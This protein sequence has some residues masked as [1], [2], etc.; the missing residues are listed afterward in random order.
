M[1]DH[2]FNEDVQLGILNKEVTELATNWCSHLEVHPAGGIAMLEQLTGLPIG[3][4]TVACKHATRGGSAAMD[5][6]AV[7][8]EFHD[9]NCVGCPHRQPVSFPNLSQ[10]V[11]ERD[12]VRAQRQAMLEREQEEAANAFKLRQE[13]RA[14]ARRSADSLRATTVDLIEEL[15]KSY[16]GERH[17][18]L[19]KLASTVPEQFD[20]AIRGLLFD[21]IDSGGEGRTHAALDALV[22]TEGDK[23]R[24]V[25]TALAALARHEAVLIA[26]DIVATHL[27]DSFGGEIDAAL[28][29]VFA[30]AS[31][32]RERFAEEVEPRFG[33]LDRAFQYYPSL[34]ER[35]L[36]EMLRVDSEAYRIVAARCV[37][38]LVKTDPELGPRLVPPM[39]NS[40]R[41]RDT[42]YGEIEGARRAVTRSL[43]EAFKASPEK[44][45]GLLHDAYARGTERASILDVYAQVCGRQ[46]SYRPKEL[47]SPD[48]LRR[49]FTRL[50]HAIAD[51]QLSLEEL[52]TLRYSFEENAKHQ[53]EML[54][55]Y[56]EGLIGV[57]ALLIQHAA[58]A[59]VPP[60]PLA[61]TAPDPL[62]MLEQQNRAA[63]L[64]PLL[65]DLTKL[66]GIAAEKAP[67]RL[68]PV[69]VD[70]FDK[71]P[72]EQE[73]LRA[74]VVQMLAGAAQNR[75]AVARILPQVYRALL[76]E[77]SHVR[78]RA[79]QAYGTIAK[80]G[81]EDLPALVHECFLNLAGD[82]EGAVHVAFADVLR[83]IK[84]PQEYRARAVRNLSLLIQAYVQGRDNA[85]HTR[86]LIE[87]FCLQY[88]GDFSPEVVEALL[89]IAEGMPHDEAAQ[90]VVALRWKLRRDPSWIALAASLA[91]M[92][93]LA[94]YRRH[95]LLQ[96]LARCESPMVAQHA[97]AIRRAV[98]L[99]VQEMP[100]PRL[101]HD[102]DFVNVTAEK[103]MLAGEW[104]EVQGLL[105]EVEA[106]YAASPVTKWRQMRTS[107]QRTAVDAERTT[108]VDERIERARAWLGVEVETEIDLETSLRARFAAVVALGEG[109]D[110]GDEALDGA[111]VALQVSAA[112]IEDDEIRQEYLNFARVLDALVFLRNWRDA[113]RS[114][115]RDAD[116]FRLAAVEAAKD[117]AK[118]ASRFNTSGLTERIRS[119]REID[120]VPVL[121]AEA[122]TISLPI[123]FR[124]QQRFALTPPGPWR[125]ERR[126]DTPE[127]TIAF[128][129]FE[130][131]GKLLSESHVIAPNRVHDLSVEVMVSD[132]PEKATALKVDVLP[133]EPQ[134][135]Y[136]FP[137]FTFPRPDGPA[138]FRLNSTGRV[139]LYVAQSLLAAPFQVKYR[140]YFVPEVVDVRVSVEGQRQLQVYGYDPLAE[141]QTGHR[142]ID[143]KLLDIKNKV[144]RTGISDRETEDFMRLMV[145]LSSL[146]WRTLASNLFA[147][148]KWPEKRFQ[149][150]IA[151]ELRRD[152]RIGGEL[153]EHPRAAGG[154]TDLS[155]RQIRTELKVKRR[156]SASVSDAAAYLSQAAQYAVGSDRRTGVVCMLDTSAKT[157]APG[158]AENDVDLVV[159]DAPAGSGVPVVL[160]VVIL[161]GNLQSPSA[162]SA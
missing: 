132:W 152:T 9:E 81:V 12:R 137:E 7:A 11:G 157:G 68:L 87:A 84:L 149:S 90:T 120:D 67:N 100:L 143:R 140:A 3:L 17:Q 161:R 30:I 23:R 49:A 150:V 95:D 5:L 114:A 56:C 18:R 126:S 89:A 93:T 128:V 22:R 92:D 106:L 141:P 13:R 52:R 36:A 62:A 82:R 133:L 94:D 148:G 159:V 21:L 77:S 105:S 43:G 111:A 40:L 138:P 39:L 44:M 99:R 55:E 28:P 158:A 71:T 24:L 42:A 19:A 54:V 75:Q 38:H 153:E 60:S 47:A 29:V 59:N 50:L 1:V 119:V 102:D 66:I 51:P 112:D 41:L 79:A 34:C 37:E 139:V 32:I 146:A 72:S 113:T 142:G 160:G 145:S 88:E 85:S 45:D 35:A 107:R 96:E 73:G 108:S 116:R 25:G 48:V 144:R 155:F 57:V 117:V 162:F 103:L 33:A 16:D 27:D 151:E 97:T 131:E 58:A 8:L 123:P 64:G 129:R 61:P 20:D 26:S 101:H 156:R 118:T 46:N 86:R 2:E 134:S 125:G 127:I 83:D 53:P 104:A 91:A 69:L 10:L 110:D 78:S 135:I 76:D 31:P 115:E 63:L 98:L 74:R 6:R 70:L 136:H 124:K 80:F 154:I 109:V 147:G 65:R 14:A 15:D 121:Y 130:Y 122:L 4:R